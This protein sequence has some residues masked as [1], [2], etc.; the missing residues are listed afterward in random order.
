MFRATM[1]RLL[2]GFGV[3]VVL[4]AT[5]PYTAGAASATNTNQS[6]HKVTICHRTHSESNPYVTITVDVAAVDGEGNNDHTSHTGPVWYPGAKADGV[7]WGDI[8]P[9]YDFPAS[10]SFAG[11]SFAGYNWTAAGQAIYDAN[12]SA[13]SPSGTLAK[14]CLDNAGRVTASDLSNGGFGDVGWRL[15]TGTTSS[16]TTVLA[17]RQGTGP[18]VATGLDDGTK[19][20][21]QYKA[22]S[23]WVDEGSVVTTGSCAQPAE[24]QPSGGLTKSCVEDAGKVTATALDDGS[25]TSVQWRL[26]SG[27]DPAHTTVLA[28]RQGA[29]TLVATGLADGTKVWLQYKTGGT[30]VDEGSVVT[31]GDCAP[32]PG[33]TCTDLQTDR[34]LF[35]YTVNGTEYSYD[36]FI[37]L[38]EYHSATVS[39]RPG[40]KIPGDC[41]VHFSLASYN[42]HGATW[43]TSGTQEF[44]DHDTITLTSA[45]T[46]GTLNVTGTECY[47]QVDLYT[48]TTIYDGA[49]GVGHGPLPHYNDSVVPPNDELIG[50]WNGGEKCA[51]PVVVKPSGHLSTDCRDGASVVTA[52][53]L[54]HGSFASARWRLVTGTPSAHG[55]VVAQQSQSGALSVTGLAD[56]TKVWL[57]YSTDA[58]DSWVDEGSVVTT[59]DCTPPPVVVAPTGGFTTSCTA[60]GAKVAIGTLKS[61]SAEDVTWTLSYG[62]A[63]TTV[64]SGEVV[65]VPAGAALVLAAQAKGAAATVVQTG[66]APAACPDKAPVQGEVDKT[67][68]PPSGSL[69]AAGQTVTYTVTVRNTGTVAIDNEPA[70]DTLPAH[71]ALVPGSITGGG[72]ASVNGRSITW[73]VSLAAGA[74]ATFTYQVTVDANAPARSELL[75]R[76]VFLGDE[77]TT[78]HTV[79]ERSLAIGKTVSPAGDAEFGDTLTYTMTVTAGG[80]MGQTNVV[81]SDYL[82]GYRPGTESGTTTYVDG[83]AACDAGTCTPSYDGSAKLLTWSLGDMAPGDTR[84]VSFP[85]TI[86]T[87]EADADGGIPAVDIVNSAAV[88][89]TETPT[90]PSNEVTTP[91]TTVLGTKVGPEKTPST[92][93]TQ[94]GSVPNALPHTGA[95]LP[96]TWTLGVSGI[97]LALGAAL[98]LAGRRKPVRLPRG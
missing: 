42:T 83:S 13:P 1:R 5:M 76:V 26:V 97:F 37:S 90:T 65:A 7:F 85:V 94:G 20:W 23:T 10:G 75:N 6:D 12:C 58:G 59:G 86:D 45:V 84:V 2:G 79:G 72:T 27:T 95:G 68:T 93:S 32:P 48:G 98:L 11:K 25:F 15:V 63:S 66:T 8:I 14:D 80:N 62:T 77:A 35:L 71:V 44:V 50:A 87:P 74:S 17:T 52:S 70:V 41:A 36:G 49:A 53:D 51:P 60:T 64:T 3:L 31:T 24:Q 40:L 34:S 67:S 96:V 28:T 78:R 22:G 81:V 56:A 43:P 46:S 69:V 4:A 47:G 91:V 16:H 9:P 92:P 30:W 54:S 33:P 89:S 82:P 73:P 21:L 39:L 88:A 18:L 29:G 57:Q 61:G 55:T 38:P 19:V